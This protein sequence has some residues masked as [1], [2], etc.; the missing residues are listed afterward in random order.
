M[1]IDANMYWIPERIFTDDAL[2]EAFLKEVPEEFGWFGRLEKIEG[3]G[4]RKQ[5]VLEKPKGSPNLNYVQGDYILEKQLADMDAAG[6][7]RALLK[8]P[9]CHEWLSLSMCRLFN[10]G[11][12]E[13]AKASGGRLIPLAVVPPYGTPESLT[14]LTRCKEKL[15]M[16]AVQVS[17][18]YGKTYLD[19]E[20]FAKFFEKVNELEMNVYVHHTP[21][22]AEYQSFCDY[23]N[24]RRSYGRCVDQ[25]LAVGREMF[26]DFF[27]KYPK[28]K[29]VHS[30]LGGGFFA[31]ANMMLPHQPKGKEAVGRFQAD[32]GQVEARFREHLYFE[33]SH[34]QPWGKEPLEC[35]VNVLGADHILFGTSYPVRKEWLTEGPAFVRQLAISEEDKERILHRNAEEIYKISG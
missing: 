20:K 32:N 18:H 31:I 12:Y 10:D 19:D 2:M 9:G 4:G 14:E 34:A 7:E 28:I 26:S 13:H 6:V 24:V 27:V 25:G 35:A 5:I 15:G 3:T 22:P 17:A 16:T 30:M 33:M 23:N 21:I 29:L 8:V 11:M 1:V